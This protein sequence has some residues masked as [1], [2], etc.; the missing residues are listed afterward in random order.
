MFLDNVQ[1][2]KTACQRKQQTKSKRKEV[3]FNVPEFE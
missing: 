2:A 1:F 3:A